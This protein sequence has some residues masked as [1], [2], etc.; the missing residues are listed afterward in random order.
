ML[1][2]VKLPPAV[3]AFMSL[4]FVRGLSLRQRLLLRA[5]VIIAAWCTALALVLV[6]E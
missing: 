3:E 2:A 6:L 1:A 5:V 4:S